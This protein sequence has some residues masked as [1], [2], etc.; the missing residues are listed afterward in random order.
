MQFVQEAPSQKF[1][2]QKSHSGGMAYMAEH[3]PSN[4]EAQSSNYS[5]TKKKKKPKGNF[6]ISMWFLKSRIHRNTE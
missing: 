1:S 4:C 5:A 2:T 3:L 6:S